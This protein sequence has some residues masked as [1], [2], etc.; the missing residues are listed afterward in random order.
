MSKDNNQHLSMWNGWSGSRRGI[1]VYD[2]WLQEYLPLLK[3]DEMIL[4]L[5]CGIG[6]NTRYLI[7]QGFQVLS[8]DYS[9]E[10]L[11]NVKEF[12]KGSQTKY[13][14]MND[15]F[16][17]NDDSF[18]VIVADISLHYFLDTK[19]IQIMKE[20]RRILKPDGILLARVSSIHDTFN[21]SNDDD[22]DS[23]YHDYGS[24]GQRY[25]NESDLKR[26]FGLIGDFEYREVTMVRDEPYYRHPK[27][28]YQLKVC[29]R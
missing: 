5:G 3:Y 24:Y 7:E 26:Y 17:F 4:D 27:K 6:A 12:I 10:A 2:L 22:P 16:L 28:L 21:V 14:N 1:P 13:L 18:K 9:L 15:P 29:K 20:I 25:M 11:K 8:C 19:T 23:R